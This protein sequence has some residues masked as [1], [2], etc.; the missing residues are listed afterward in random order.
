[1]TIRPT[2]NEFSSQWKIPDD[3]L[4]RWNTI[5]PPLPSNDEVSPVHPNP[6][7]QLEN[8]QPAGP[9]RPP[10][11][12]HVLPNSPPDA[13]IPPNENLPIGYHVHNMPFRM[14]PVFQGTAPRRLS[15]INRYLAPEPGSVNV[16]RNLRPSDG[17]HQ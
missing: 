5:P 17:K 1:M 14:S 2:K 16:P 12:G 11:N 6:E 4:E 8:H 13:N 9:L 15:S 7:R 10:Y 3:H